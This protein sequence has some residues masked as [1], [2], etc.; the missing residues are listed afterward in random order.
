MDSMHFQ[1]NP[2]ILMPFWPTIRRKQGNKY[3]VGTTKLITYGSRKKEIGEAKII[4][5]ATIEF[6]AINNQIALMVSG[7]YA[8]YIKAILTKMY[9]GI[10][11]N[12]LL[13]II[14]LEWTQRYLA[15]QQDLIQQWWES[16]IAQTPNYQDFKMRLAS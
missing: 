13:N 6:G 5:T 11:E 7:K 3:I 2:N 8:N 1:F 14:V 16:Q 9:P 12:D 4:Y 15:E 10:Q